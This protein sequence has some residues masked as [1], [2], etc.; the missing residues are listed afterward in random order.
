LGAGCREEKEGMRIRVRAAKI[1]SELRKTFEQY[2]ASVMQ[3][4]LERILVSWHKGGR[5][6]PDGHRDPLLAWL[7][8]QH[9]NDE[10]R[11]TMLIAMEL[12]ILIFVG[13]E[14]VFAIINF[15]HAR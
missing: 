9:D 4:I 3:V 6:G 1:D 14:L 7:T 15:L 5:T 2:G 12:S 13:A 10:R 11:E 8:E